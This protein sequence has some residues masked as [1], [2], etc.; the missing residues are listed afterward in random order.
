MAEIN[1]LGVDVSEW[2]GSI[3]WNEFKRQGV[4]AAIIRGGFGSSTSQKD[5]MFQRHIDGAL[6]AG[7][8]TGVY[9]FGYAYTVDGARREADTCHEVIKAY[10][11]KL[12]LPVFYDWE[13][14]SAR[15]AQDHGVTPTKQLVTDMTIAFMDRMKELGYQ[16]GYYTNLDYMSRYYDYNRI[17][18]YDLW[19]AYYSS[20]KPNYD[21]TVQQYTSTG[22][23]SGYG[24][25]LDLNRVYKDY[26]EKEDAP[27][28]QPEVKPT[29]PAQTETIYTVQ[30][31]DTLSSIGL[32]YGMTY[33]ELAQYNGISNPHMI[34][35]GQQIK[36]PGKTN[37]VK[38]EGKVHTV[39]SGDTLSG[40]ANKYG[41][42]W[43][44]LAEYNRIANP[45]II[46]PGQKI[47][48]P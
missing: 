30:K 47:N 5:S 41:T 46:Y 28:P 43:Q 8:K 31:G 9:W 20:Q 16:A 37:A 21:C 14:D 48:I 38:P 44:V 24:G 34:F 17:K 11:G 19:M 26:G 42:S 22:R 27:V 10:K 18:A 3:D 25:N 1:K 45:N 32:K 35:P 29:E 36:I 15:Y 23:L 12:T 6:A 40:I 33:Q 2:Q 7:I 4:G 13:Y 39:V